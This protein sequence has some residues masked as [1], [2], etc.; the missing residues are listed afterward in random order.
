[1][2]STHLIKVSDTMRKRK[3]MSNNHVVLMVTLVVKKW[4]EWN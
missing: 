1:M 3:S 2:R 4:R